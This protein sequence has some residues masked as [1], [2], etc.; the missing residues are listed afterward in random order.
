ML[1]LA[2]P[3]SAMEFTAPEAP[4]Q[5]VDLIP[6]SADSFGEGLWNVVIWALR[7]ADDSLDE[8][9]SVCLSAAAA[10]LLSAL[11]EEVGTA[12]SALPIRLCTAIAVA[13]VLLSPT[14]ALISLAV[15]TIMEMNEYGK[16]LLPVMTG[17]MAAR[18]GV[19]SSASLYA[20]TALFNT[21]LSSLMTRLAT[22]M[23]YLFLGLSIGD[24][25]LS[26]S[27]LGKFR[28]LIQWGMTWVLKGALYLFTGYIT[29]TG[30]ITG[31][32]DAASV[33][34]AKMAISSAVPVVG[35]ILSD[36][37]EVV[38]ISAGT[39]GSAAGVY[40]LVTVLA[41]FAGPFV[42]VGLQYL[43]LQATAVFSKS[44]DGGGASDLIHSFAGAMGLLLAMISTQTIL[45]LISTVCFMKGVT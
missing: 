22:P 26:A 11:L 19:T 30:V 5:V 6:E 27:I 28:D 33:R 21:V 13:C 44:L 23:L 15:D 16:L 39:L 14:T 35:G 25:T 20:A 43:L 17:A 37:S 42:R 1:L 2:V 36:A 3:V 24:S 10:V 32:A 34:V 29:V 18:G 31:T 9:M 4:E 7:E 12:A 40:G 45:L 38:L 41:L 8:A